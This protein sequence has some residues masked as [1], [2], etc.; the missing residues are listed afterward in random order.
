MSAAHVRDNFGR[1][2]FCQGF[3]TVEIRKIRLFYRSSC[4]LFAHHRQDLW[5]SIC[6]P[7]LYIQL[8][9]QETVNDREIS[10]GD[11]VLCVIHKY[12]FMVIEKERWIC[13]SS[14]AIQLQNFITKPLRMVT[15]SNLFN[16]V[17]S[18]KNFPF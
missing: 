14:H 16:W 6:I 8:C 1:Q 18:N 17:R 15:F 10:F 13:D 4:F 7:N 12:L 11:L 9:M 2:V 3:V 5:L